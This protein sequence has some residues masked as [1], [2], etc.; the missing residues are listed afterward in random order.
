MLT[1]LFTSIVRVINYIKYIVWGTISTIPSTCSICLEETSDTFEMDDM[2]KNKF[3]LI[4][5]TSMMIPF[6]QF[7]AIRSCG[8]M[9]HFECIKKLIHHSPTNTIKC[10][11]CRQYGT[12]I[13]PR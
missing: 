4:G 9:F 12:F 2:D 5:N 13:F 11:M 6:T 10:P 8:H 7:I 1:F 3:Y